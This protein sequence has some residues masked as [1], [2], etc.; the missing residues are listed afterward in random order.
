MSFV[1]RA[2]SSETLA[3]GLDL[4]HSS[5]HSIMKDIEVEA[6]QAQLEELQDSFLIVLLVWCSWWTSSSYSM[7]L[8]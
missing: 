1:S 7:R 6:M 4:A 8:A 5:S 3:R 2:W